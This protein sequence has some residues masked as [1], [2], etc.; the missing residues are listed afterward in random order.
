MSQRVSPA[1]WVQTI[2]RNG[3]QQIS[4]GLM[5]GDPFDILSKRAAQAEQAGVPCARA[6]VMVTNASEDYS[7]VKVSITISVP[8]A[9]GEGDIS[10]AGE[11]G[12]IKAH[13]MV[14]EASAA[15]GLTLLG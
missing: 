1:V 11:A 15:L 6:S 2:E 7:R 3:F 12:F 9:C 4:E 8:C 5:S 14:N 10:L 13:Q